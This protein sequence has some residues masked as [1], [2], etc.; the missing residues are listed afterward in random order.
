MRKIILLTF[1]FG[2]LFS[3][4][5]KE[6]K[7]NNN[8]SYKDFD[9]ANTFYEKNAFDSAFFYYNKAVSA[10]RD[11]L[12]IGKSLFNMAITQ[13]VQGDYFGSNE[14]AIKSIS[15]FRKSDSLYFLTMASVYNTIAI[16]KNDLREYNEAIE[17]YKKSISINFN[18]RDSVMSQN[19][20]AVAFYKIR[21]YNEAKS[22]YTKLLKNDTVLNNIDILT[23]VIDNFGYTK[24]LEN[25]NY[26]GAPELLKALN[27]RK[28]E[29][30]LWGQNSSYSHLTDYYTKKQP[31]SALFYANHMYHI[32]QKL[33]SPDDQLGA[34]QKL[35]KLSPPKETK[36]FFGIYQ[37]LDD[38]VQ[39]ARSAAK[40]QFALIRYETEKNKADFLKAK[41]DNTE[42]EKNI[43]IKN[44]G[45]G[46]L[47]VFLTIGYFWYR[48]RQKILKQEKEIEVKNTE[49]KYVK[50]VHDR[51]A[52]RIYQVIDEIDNRPEMQKD[53]VAEKLDIIYNISRDLSYESIDTKYT[54]DF[55]KELTAMFSSYQSAKVLIVINGNEEKLWSGTNDT[56]KSE[57]FIILQELMTNMS[58]HSEANH[59]QL[60]F[61]RDK[62]RITIL[63][64]DNGKGIQNFS[65][66][67]GLKNTETRIKNISGVITFDTKP[68]EGLTIKFS[69]PI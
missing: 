52:N 23:K 19:N 35:I 65:P 12:L 69:F 4:N 18:S 11:S 55:A 10:N 51:V 21:K 62:E 31:D 27:I 56:V 16:N 13:S 22:I 32:A 47:I 14:T 64:S 8:V 40:N 46:I 9:K 34:L 61:L 6:S 54:E 42:K 44:I 5:R 29:N 7:K 39:N 50:K 1:A 57:V 28:K 2:I 66:G 17:W 33:K 25:S 20:L 26:I 3:C 48:R 37:Q 24:W 58:K 60:N 49:L 63:Y 15:Y 38:S 59:V 53:E 41:A 43:L 36:Q 30:D 68:N 45:I 67:N